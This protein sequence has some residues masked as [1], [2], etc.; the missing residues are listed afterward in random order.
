ML[1]KIEEKDIDVIAKWFKD[2]HFLE[3]YDYVPP[4]PKSYDEVRRIIKEYEDN[5]DSV[6]FGI[7][8]EGS[9]RLI[10]IAGFYDI[11]WENQV[12]T[13]F[14]GI[15]DKA[16][17][18]QGYGKRALIELINFG[19]KHLEIHRIQLNVISCNERA[20]K[21]YESLGFV[22]EGTYR[23]FLNR[24][25]KRMDMYL[26]SILKPEWSANNSYDKI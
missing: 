13:L 12:A 2:I 14:I 20:K 15:G 21:V 9:N 25:D 1:S 3:F 16:D 10:G 6:V 26:Y 4:I 18:G 17:R 19:F 23:E 22:R 8:E 11:L 5:N 7:V 24:N